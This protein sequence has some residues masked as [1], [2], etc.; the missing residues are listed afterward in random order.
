MAAEDAGIGP[1]DI[2]LSEYTESQ[3]AR[4]AAAAKYGITARELSAPEAGM[5]EDTVFMW[6]SKEP[7]D[8]KPWGGLAGITKAL[9]VDP[10]VGLDANDDQELQDREYAFGSNARYI[11]P[12]VTPVQITMT[13][14]VVAAFPSLFTPPPLT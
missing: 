12:G 1:G 11:P 8:L 3:R 13:A 10:K 2:E 6:Q 4:N 7:I 5:D 9:H 14:A